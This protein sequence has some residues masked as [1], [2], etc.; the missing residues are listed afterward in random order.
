MEMDSNVVQVA[1]ACSTSNT[2]GS[3]WLGEEHEVEAHVRQLLETL[4]R[5]I[6][7]ASPDG[8]P[9]Y[10]THELLEI[11][12]VPFTEIAG[13]NWSGQST[14]GLPFRYCLMAL[15][16]YLTSLLSRRGFD[17]PSRQAVRRVGQRSNERLS[18]RECAVLA[19]IAK[20]QS[21]KRV[22]QTLKITPETVKS[23]VKRTFIKLGTKTR[24]EAVSRATELGFLWT[25]VDRMPSLM[26]RHS[27]R[28]QGV[29][30]QLGAA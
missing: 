15:N 23:H 17:N 24:A 30:S 13:T 26:A 4:P 5:M 7:I 21:N 1:E 19:L 14:A 12:G 2:R 29:T 20:G 25:S 28:D 8:Q 3:G 11:V 22:A 18:A 27:S 16:S 9:R 6:R 10:V